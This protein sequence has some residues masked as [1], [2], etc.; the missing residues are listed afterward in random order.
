MPN[1][2]NAE[3]SPRPE[4][5]EQREAAPESFAEATKKLIRERV[6]AV[7]RK[8]RELFARLKGKL[9]DEEREEMNAVAGTIEIHAETAGTDHTREIDRTMEAS[10]NPG[11]R[12]SYEA[13]APELDIAE[14]RKLKDE[15]RFGKEGAEQLEKETIREEYSQAM[16]KV[17]EKL[18]NTDKKREVELTEDREKELAEFLPALEQSLAAEARGA[19]STTETVNRFLGKAIKGLAYFGAAGAG[20]ALLTPIGGIAAT[21]GVR[22]IDTAI[23][24]NLEKRKV[25]QYKRKIAQDTE[26]AAK[27]REEIK[28][29]LLVLIESKKRA[30]FLEQIK[31]EKQWTTQEEY[32]E[33]AKHYKERALEYLNTH[34][35]EDLQKLE[36]EKGPEAAT[37]AMEEMATQISALYALDDNSERIIND[38]EESRTT[39]WQSFTKA[40]NKKFHLE[41]LGDSSYVNKI[42]S[43]SAAMGIGVFIRTAAKGSKWSRRIAMAYGGY[44]IG[45]AIGDLVAKG[46]TPESLAKESLDGLAQLNRTNPDNIQTETGRSQYSQAIIQAK[47]ALAKIPRT[48]ENKLKV[49]KLKNRIA[50]HEFALLN[51]TITQSPEQG[52]QELSDFFASAFQ[53]EQTAQEQVTAESKKS[54]AIKIGSRVGLAL[55]GGALAEGIQRFLETRT[56]EAAEPEGAAPQKPKLPTEKPEFIKAREQ[57][58]E[59]GLKGRAKFRPAEIRERIT[60]ETIEKPD[61]PTPEKMGMPPMPSKHIEAA[62]PE[63]KMPKGID[64]STMPSVSEGVEGTGGKIIPEAEPPTTPEAEVGA[65][66]APTE[67][68]Q[69]EAAPKTRGLTFAEQQSEPTPSPAGTEL[70]PTSPLPQEQVSLSKLETERIFTG[71][72]YQ[73]EEKLGKLTLPQVE[74]LYA[75]TKQDFV[76]KFKGIG[77]VNKKFF[78]NLKEQETAADKLNQVLT[79]NLTEFQ[80][81]G[82]F[83]DYADYVKRI[84]AL[85]KTISIISK[86]G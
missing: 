25:N 18:L 46:H 54:K 76:E 29:N 33:K 17:M 32:I 13:E 75:S 42:Y 30:E 67:A 64:M 31:E 8:T 52:E 48:P 11:P 63:T 16:D 6:S 10:A 78:D 50:Q 79:K 41:A 27:Q 21:G 7:I 20:T 60:P 69:I 9:T 57:E 72:L 15:L 34:K 28:S 86:K 49:E 84:I 62:L 23:S 51:K 56:A 82:L 71:Q 19:K 37:A 38:T 26:Q 2:T 81:R 35:P 73:V 43:A 85:E 61:M 53:K 4:R 36:Q 77:G 22:L 24:V 66:Q 58:I 68:Q 74:K 80:K 14:A 55:L 59:Q 45:G 39:A 1:Q 44:K 3:Q 83:K 70:E 65:D 12:E 40:V 47:A 5:Q